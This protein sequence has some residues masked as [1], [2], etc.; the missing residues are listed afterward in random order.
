MRRRP[1]HRI[2]CVCKVNEK[3]LEKDEKRQINVMEQNKKKMKFVHSL[4]VLQTPH[5]HIRVR[6]RVRTKHTAQRKEQDGKEMK[7]KRNDFCS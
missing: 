5:I 1:I 3:K 4:S 7:N 6:V 2:I